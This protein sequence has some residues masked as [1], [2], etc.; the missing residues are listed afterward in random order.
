MRIYYVSNNIMIVPRNIIVPLSCGRTS[1]HKG[2]KKHREYTQH[3]N[4]I[5]TFCNLSET[6]SA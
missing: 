1:V 3:Y 4:N 5:Q 2:G 6:A